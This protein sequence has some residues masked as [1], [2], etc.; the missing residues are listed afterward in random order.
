[1]FHAILLQAMRE[2]LVGLGLVMLEG[3]K[4]EETI[5]EAVQPSV[6]SNLAFFD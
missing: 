5:R 6:E 3:S 4:M 1:M 2:V